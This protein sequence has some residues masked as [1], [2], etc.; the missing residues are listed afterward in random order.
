MDFEMSESDYTNFSTLIYRKA[1]INLHEGKKGL[2]KARLRKY[3]RKTSFRSLEEYYQYLMN[4]DTGEEMIHLLDVIS[5]NLTYFFREPKHYDFLRSKALPQVKESSRFLNKRTIRVWSAGCSS[6]EEAY[7]LGIVLKEF[8]GSQKGLQFQI[9]A[10]D[11]STRMLKKASDGI[12]EEEKLEKI[13]YELKSRYFQRG[14]NKR[15]GYFRVKPQLRNVIVFRRLN[16]MEP[17]PS[18]STFQ[19]IFCRNVMIY[20][21]KHTQERIVEKFYGALEKGG[22]FFVGHS[23]S[24]TNINHAFQYIQPSVY[25]K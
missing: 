14:I 22:F 6:G 13:P 5:T 23:E 25:R 7:S 18:G 19:I 11:I 16:L 10:T 15:S 2:L 9:L 20:F 12:Y 8:I 3:L 1:G 24:L 21:D 4:N 17:F